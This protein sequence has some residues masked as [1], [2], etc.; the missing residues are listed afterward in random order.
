MEETGSLLDCGGHVCLDLHL[1]FYTGYGC[2]DAADGH[3]GDSGVGVAVQVRIADLLVLFFGICLYGCVGG[4]FIF[5]GVKCFS[6][7]R[8]C[9]DL[10]QRFFHT[11]GDDFSG[12]V[13]EF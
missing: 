12:R 5:D 13:V 1:V 10:I 9:K 8:G 2:G 7:Y 3:T 6:V 4:K 11:V